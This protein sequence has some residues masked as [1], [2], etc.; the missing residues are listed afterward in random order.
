MISITAVGVATALVIVAGV[1]RLLDPA[2]RARHEVPLALPISA[3]AAATILSAALAADRVQGLVH[4]KHLL[5]VPLVIVAANGFASSAQ[6]RRALGW[7]FGAVSL[8]SLYAVAQTWACSSGVEP[9]PWIGLLLRVKLE[10]CRAAS[11]FR[12]KGF[13]S[14]YMT[15]GGSLL[16]ALSLLLALLAR[17]ARREAISLIVTTVLALGALGL[18]YAR[19]AWV[20]LLASLLVLMAVTRRLTLVA[21]VLAAVLVA[22]SVPSAVQTRALSMLTTPD[23]TARERLYFWHAGLRMVGEAPLLGLGP[24][25]VRRSYPRYKHPDAIRPSTSHL[26]NNLVQIAAERG[27]LGLATWLWIWVAFFRR[28]GR[29]YQALPRAPAMSRALVAGSLA[30]VAGFLAAGFFEYNFGDAEVIGLVWVV[31]AFPF[32]CG[33]EPVIEPS[34]GAGPRP[35]CRE[36][37]V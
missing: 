28:A 31:M 14:I 2:L 3:F 29:A 5:S 1:L 25:G 15:L 16:V 19:N 36:Q 27:L 21:A 22:L 35:V 34:A 30:A 9:P 17:A 10:T 7:F 32:V 23:Q 37:P 33:R 8:A 4:S 13:F 18:T 26:H 20:G 6:V 11:P 24:G 12:A